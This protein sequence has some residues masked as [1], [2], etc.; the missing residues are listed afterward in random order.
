MYST[1]LGQL[2]MSWETHIWLSSTS[3]KRSK[4]GDSWVIAAKYPQGL[5]TALLCSKDWVIGK[6]RLTIIAR[7]SLFIAKSATAAEKRMLWTT[8]AICTNRWG[9]QTKRGTIIPKPFTLRG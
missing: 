8:L 6:R 7:L 4:S 1:I 2:T 3:A 9:I 5:T